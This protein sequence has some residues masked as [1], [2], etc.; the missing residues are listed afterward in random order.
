[1]FQVKTTNILRLSPYTRY[2]VVYL[3]RST[4]PTDASFGGV[5][6]HR[7]VCPISILW[8]SLGDPLHTAFINIVDFHLYEILFVSALLT[9]MLI[10]C[11]VCAYYDMWKG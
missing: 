6:I 10:K 5:V 1:M 2:T 7:E 3:I 9:E 11:S 4:Y 8:D